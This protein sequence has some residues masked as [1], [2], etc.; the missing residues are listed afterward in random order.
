MSQ[1]SLVRVSVSSF[2]LATLFHQNSNPVTSAAERCALPDW[3]PPHRKD[4]LPARANRPRMEA[5]DEPARG[6]SASVARVRRASRDCKMRPAARD[7]DRRQ[8]GW[9]WSCNMPRE[10]HGLSPW[11]AREQAHN[12]DSRG[13]G[14]TRGDGGTAWRCSI[15][16]RHPI[17]LSLSAIFDTGGDG[18]DLIAHP[19][20][21]MWPASPSKIL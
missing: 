10:G 20:A 21:G 5:D 12:S 7:A 17:R 3:R 8:K 13:Q 2:Q 1:R 9:S 15:R 14:A 4:P 18:G 11:H 16:Y 19:A 6:C